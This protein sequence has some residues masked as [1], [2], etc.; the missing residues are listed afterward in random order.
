MPK[1]PYHELAPEKWQKTTERLL[2]VYPL[3]RDEIVA[4]ILDAWESMFESKI[5]RHGIRIGRDL[6]PTPQIMGSYLHELIP[7]EF[8]ARY[9]GQ[10]RG[11]ETAGEKD[12]V[13]IPD[14]R[15]S[16]EIKT[17]SHK[18]KIYANRSYAQ[19]SATFKKDKS[20]YY[21]AVNFEKFDRTRR[22]PQ[23]PRIRRIRFG[24]LDHT[25][26]KAQ[27]KPT[28]QQASLRPESERLKLL[29]IYEAA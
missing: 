29:V 8:A 24:W 5:G 26:W 23:E 2:R 28:G 15:F 1:S 19:E 16:T 20:G 14:D 22:T 25:D 13:Y 3:S 7:L 18:A 27:E 6:F 9:P 21:I 11:D 4:P 10:W 17:S 12:L